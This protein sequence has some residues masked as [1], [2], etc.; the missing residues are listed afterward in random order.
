MKKQIQE[1]TYHEQYLSSNHFSVPFF[2]AR[3]ATLRITGENNDIQPGAFESDMIKAT[4]RCAN[5]LGFP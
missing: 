5:F 2:L 3:L 4:A 1:F